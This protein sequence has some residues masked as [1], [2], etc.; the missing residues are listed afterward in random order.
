MP[1]ASADFIRDLLLL[2]LRLL[3]ISYGRKLWLYNSNV[4]AGKM[5]TNLRI[6]VDDDYAIMLNQL[7]LARTFNFLIDLVDRTLTR[8]HSIMFQ[9]QYM[10]LNR[11]N[12]LIAPLPGN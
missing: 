9:I 11:Y 3:S 7:I 1:I 2:L 12:Q 5:N 8:D 4:L 10:M 6:Y